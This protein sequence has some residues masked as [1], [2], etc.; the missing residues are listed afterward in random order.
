MVKTRPKQNRRLKTSVSTSILNSLNPMAKPEKQASLRHVPSVDQLLRSDVAR[1]L[2]EVVGLKKL[3][4]IARAVTAEI[5]AL[6]RSDEAN[7]DN[8]EGLLAEAIRRM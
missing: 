1:E 6:V 4:N 7:A 2:R 5:R 3:T 8:A